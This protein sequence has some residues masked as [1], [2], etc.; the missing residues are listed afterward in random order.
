M[1]DALSHAVPYLPRI[2]SPIIGFSFLYMTFFM[3]QGQVGK[4]QNRLVDLWVRAG[5]THETFLSNQAGIIKSS[6]DI[7]EM[8]LPW[9]PDS[10]ALVEP[11]T[12][13]PVATPT[14][15]LEFSA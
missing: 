11:W 9:L 10:I 2:I 13:P 7:A 6:A 3:Y 15:P 1:F 4:I 8:S 5:S 14:K 12:D